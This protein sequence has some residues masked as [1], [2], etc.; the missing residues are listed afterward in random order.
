VVEES[1]VTMEGEVVEEEIVGVDEG[2]VVS[3]DDVVTEE[4]IDDDTSIAI[5]DI[6]GMVCGRGGLRSSGA[7]G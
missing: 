3:W 4:V 7:P 1:V 6:P 2:E 5:E